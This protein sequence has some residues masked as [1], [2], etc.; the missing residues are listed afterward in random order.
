[1]IAKTAWLFNPH[2]SLDFMGF[3]YSKKGKK[4]MKD[5]PRGDLL[6]QWLTQWRR[7]TKRTRW[8]F[9]NQQGS[10]H[11]PTRVDPGGF[12]FLTLTKL[13]RHLGSPA[14]ISQERIVESECDSQIIG[15]PCS[16]CW[17][18][19]WALKFPFI[20]MRKTPNP[21]LLEASATQKWWIPG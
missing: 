20:S 18:Q 10:F 12:S 11:G 1:M 21:G 16:H 13:F 2:F 17:F 3:S 9:A 8:L 15:I 19:K 4:H 7:N 5:Q 6:D 14:S